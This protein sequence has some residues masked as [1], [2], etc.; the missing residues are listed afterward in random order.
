MSKPFVISVA[1]PGS[2]SGKT[3]LVCALL[4]HLATL[5][6]VGAVK[7][8]TSTPDHMCARTNLPC[9]CLRFE[10]RMR[11]LKDPAYI[12]KVGKDTE[13]MF[14]AGARPTWWLQTTSDVQIESAQFL[15]EE[16]SGPKIWVVEGAGPI[17]GGLA[18]L[19]ILV[20]KAD[21]SEPKESWFDLLP[22][23]HVIARSHEHEIDTAINM[24]P[25]TTS[26]HHRPTLEF[27]G[28]AQELPKKFIDFLTH[29]FNGES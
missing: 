24:N 29:F 25:W 7:I 5:G 23:A 14:A 12:N 2:N 10:G 17:R 21:G 4:R 6:D 19:A 18:D 9:D 26:V 8:A 3:H 27:S 20:V 28:R 16:L 11:L 22:Q 15:V 1:G 13:A